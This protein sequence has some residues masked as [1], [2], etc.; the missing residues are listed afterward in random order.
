MP[1]R[2]PQL[3]ASYFGTMKNGAVPVPV[4][5]MALAQDY[6]YYLNDSR[7][8]ALIVD[9]ALAPTFRQIL[10]KARY[11]KHVLVLGLSKAELDALDYDALVANASPEPEAVA[12]SKDDMAFWM[13]SS[14]TT[15]TP[16][17]ES[18]S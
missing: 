14:G 6:L 1:S 4:S 9:G 12:T 5:T 16:K 7:A 15:G 10:S 13:Y 17:G 2:L 18:A 11:L 8:K 3:L